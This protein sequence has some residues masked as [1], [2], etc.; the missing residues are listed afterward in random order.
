MLDIN[1]VEQ[2]LEDWDLVKLSGFK[3]IIE[4]KRYEQKKNALA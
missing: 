3:R 1:E 4:K 2:A